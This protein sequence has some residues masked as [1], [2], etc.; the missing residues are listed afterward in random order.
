MALIYHTVQIKYWILDP[1]LRSPASILAVLNAT[2]LIV[3]KP[4]K[5]QIKVAKVRHGRETVSILQASN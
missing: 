4:L 1:K 3:R 5:M 2:D